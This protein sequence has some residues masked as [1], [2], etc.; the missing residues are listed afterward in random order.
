MKLKPDFLPHVLG[1]LGVL[2]AALLAGLVL[3][4]LQLQPLTVIVLVAGV[5][6]GAAVEGT[7]ANDNRLARQAGLPPPH[8]VSLRDLFNSAL[9]CLVA[10]ALI[11]LAA[12]QHWLPLTG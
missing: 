2:V 1:G 12:R 8:E 4:H 11:E 5:L 3:L 10:A 7:Q 9:P 6:A